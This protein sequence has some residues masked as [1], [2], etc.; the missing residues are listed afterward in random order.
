MSMAEFKTWLEGFLD[1]AGAELSK[2]QADKIREKLAE[3]RAA[4]EPIAPLLPYQPLSS[5]EK[6]GWITTTCKNA[7]DKAVWHGGT[8]C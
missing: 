8:I 6:P 2:E 3:V 4:P 5:P 7:V 1:A